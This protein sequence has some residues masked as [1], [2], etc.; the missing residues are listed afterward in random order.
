M[1]IRSSDSN[2]SSA[3]CLVRD[4]G[5]TEPVFIVTKPA[6]KNSWRAALMSAFSASPFWENGR[7]RG[8]P[9]PPPPSESRDWRGVC[10]NG[11]QNLEPQGF[12]GQNLENKGVR[13]LLAIS[14]CTASALTMICSLN[15]RVKVRCH[16]GLWKTKER[17]RESRPSQKARRGWAT[18]H[19][20]SSVGRLR[21]NSML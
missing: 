12:R 13:A 19:T 9:P 14:A 7:F 6:E 1:P 3:C 15:F 17:S 18:P 8:Y 2:I 5:I 11:L 4:I 10:K 21:G 16:I 20:A